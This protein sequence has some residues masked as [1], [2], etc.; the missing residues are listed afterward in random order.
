MRPLTL[1]MSAFG[2]YAGV[3]TVDFTVFGE[4]GLYLISGDTGAGKT[5]IFDAI[6]F[7]LFDAPSGNNRSKDML[8]SDFSDPQTPTYV[9]LT[10]AYQGKEYTVRRNPAYQRPKERGEGMTLQQ[11]DATWL[12]PGE[13]HPVTGNSTVTARIQDILGINR[14]QFAQIAM[15]AQGDFMKLLF[16]KTEERQKIFRDIF[17]TKPYLDIQYAL[18]AE[19][20]RLGHLCEDGRKSLSQFI[21]GIVCDPESERA[22]GVE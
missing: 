16:S 4:K 14:D 20:E 13:E 7:A 9:E 11:A 2:P 19:A 18:K 10:F 22:A 5:T 17:K 3:E 1:T 12:L 8:R 21:A 15:I 6:S